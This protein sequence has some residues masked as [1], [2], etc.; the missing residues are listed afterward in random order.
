MHTCTTVCITYE[1]YVCTVYSYLAVSLYTG[2]VYNFC[3]QSVLLLQMQAVYKVCLTLMISLT[4][5]RRWLAGAE[6]PIHLQQ[7]TS[8]MPWQ[9]CSCFQP[10]LPKPLTSLTLCDNTRTAGQGVMA[11]SHMCLLCGQLSFIDS[12]FT[13]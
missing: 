2:N 10:H 12:I 1:A 3:T 7:L 8:T 11:L 5:P 6:N 9:T 4:Q 13:L